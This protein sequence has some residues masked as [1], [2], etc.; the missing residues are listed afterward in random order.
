EELHG[1][2]EAYHLA[3]G[4]LSPR[5]HV[6]PG[7]RRG[8]GVPH[9]GQRSGHEPHSWRGLAVRRAGRRGSRNWSSRS[10]GRGQRPRLGEAHDQAARLHLELLERTFDEDRRE[11]IDCGKDAGLQLLLSAW[12][13]GWWLCLMRR[14]IQ[15]GHAS[16]SQRRRMMVALWPPKPKALLMAV[17]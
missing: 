6:R 2:D 12:V 13:G 8:G 14:L 3:D 5:A 9:A 4:D 17:L 16:A 15:I 7:S 1:L 10:G 11:A